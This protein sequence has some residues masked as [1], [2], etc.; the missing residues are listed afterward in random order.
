M[1]PFNAN[2]KCREEGGHPAKLTTPQEWQTVTAALKARRQISVVWLGLT[3]SASIPFSLYGRSA[4]WADGTVAYYVNYTKD[5][6]S[7]LF[8]CGYFQERDYD[9]IMLDAD[10]RAIF[11]LGQSAPLCERTTAE[12]EG[13]EVPE[14]IELQYPENRQLRLSHVTCSNGQTMLSFLSCE[15][16]SRGAYV[17]ESVI[18]GSAQSTIDEGGGPYFRCDSEVEHVPYTL[19]CDHRQDCADNSDED[20]CQFPPCTGNTPLKCGT[21]HQCL[22]LDRWCD[23]QHD[24]SNGE[25]ERECTSSISFIPL[26][27]KYV[28]IPPPAVVHFDPTANTTSAVTMTTLTLSNGSYTC[29]DSHFQCPGGGYCMPVFVR[30]NGVNDC[31]RHEDEEGCYTYTCPGFYRCRKS[32]ICLHADHVCDGLYHCPLQDDEQYCHIHCPTDCTCSGFA[33]ACP[34]LFP[35]HQFAD[36]R[37]LDASDSGL[38]L[39]HMTHNVLLIHLSVARCGLTDFGNVTLPNLQSLDLSDNHLVSVG[40]GDLSL[41]SNLRDLYLSG[42]PLISILSTTSDYAQHFPLMNS[43]DLS[44]INMKELKVDKLTLMPNLKILNFSNNGIERIEGTF[45]SLPHLTVLDI[46]GCPVHNF[47]RNLLRDLEHFQRLYAQNYKLCCPLALPVGF[48][49]KNCLAPFSE[50][51]SCE[52]LL[53]SDLYRVLL[54]LFAALALMG[55]LGSLIIRIFVLKQSAKSGF[56]TFVSHLC[57]SDFVM[58]VYLAIIGL[59][60][61]LYLGSYL[62]EDNAWRHSA[63]CKVAG[64]LSLLSCEVSAFIVCFITLDRFLAL[65]FP[66]S[67]FHFSS[68]ASHVACAATWLLGVGVAAVPLLPATSHWQF[69]SQTGICIPL[70]VTRNDFMGR[71][72]SFGVM[73]VLNFVLFLLMAVGQV[74]IYTSIQSSRM[75]LGPDS[76][77]KE[78]DVNIARR[79]I[80]IAVTDFLCWFPIGL[81]GLLAS[82]GVAVPGEVNVAMAILVLP[83]NSALNPFLYSLNMLLER[84]RRAREQRLMQALEASL[85]SENAN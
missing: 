14:N 68:K 25:D 4:V 62:W 19:V 71:S 31:P 8:L 5:I 17:N 76:S 28:A 50:V 37:Y 66:F 54:S 73:I 7:S 46:H 56:G 9:M 10:C 70:P 32:R 20:F 52:S 55:N 53:R 18:S 49:P 29:P 45:K 12:V 80:T 36:L 78:Q 51:S 63:A 47:E 24:C 27:G 65:R 23:G 21:S 1:R 79:L 57:V 41:F 15:S 2:E 3:T 42:N 40:T 74:F 77:R 22:A 33:F 60:D 26:L 85:V 82:G 83:L 43:L 13:Q 39:E 16:S 84:R 6:S 61:R 75:S 11:Q 30:C 67:G 44:R 72:Y 35:V 34:H 59:A 81:L 64:F 48:N 69:Y 38:N 58:G